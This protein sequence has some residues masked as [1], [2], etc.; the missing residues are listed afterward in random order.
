MQKNQ[1]RKIT[2]DKKFNDENP[3]K[4]HDFHF[5]T[6]TFFHQQFFKSF[7]LFCKNL[8]FEEKVFP[9]VAPHM[10]KNIYQRDTS[11]FLFNAYNYL[12]NFKIKIPKLYSLK[13]VKK[14]IQ[15]KK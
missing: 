2:K 6:K 10:K 11:F 9:V 5:L 3:K 15:R 7:T 14:K 13:I 4:N 8:Y 12:K 1:I